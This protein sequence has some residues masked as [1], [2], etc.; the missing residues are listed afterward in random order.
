M[1]SAVICQLSILYGD[2][3]DP[4]F[5]PHHKNANDTLEKIQTHADAVDHQN[6]NPCVVAE[7]K[8]SGQT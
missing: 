5:A 3:L 2:I 8:G 4:A 1:Q 7:D 6:R